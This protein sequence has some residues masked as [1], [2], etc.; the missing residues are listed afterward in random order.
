V[1]LQP[2][3]WRVRADALA[4]AD[5]V[6]AESRQLVEQQYQVCGELAA[7]V[8]V[9]DHRGSRT[10]SR[11]AFLDA[12]GASVFALPRV[13]RVPSAALP[14]L[15]TVAA[16]RRITASSVVSS[17]PKKYSGAVVPYPDVLLASPTMSA[18]YLHDL[19]SSDRYTPRISMRG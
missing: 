8:L 11:R 6:D 19:G 2:T 10:S 7:Q 9:V 5:E 1:W 4:K 16:A 15:L 3:G 14:T 17:E 12:V 18:Y 13:R